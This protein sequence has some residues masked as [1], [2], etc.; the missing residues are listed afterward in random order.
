MTAE[1]TALGF[2]A[3][4]VDWAEN[5]HITMGDS[6]SI[7]LATSAGQATFDRL[8]EHPRLA[9]V[10]FAPPCGTA[11][12]AREKPVAKGR[13]G[14]PPLRSEEFPYG[15]LSLPAEH[16]LAMRHVQ[17]A[18]SQYDFAARSAKAL[19][20]RRV[21]WSMENPASKLFC[22]L[23]P[24]ID[25]LDDEVGD[26]FLH[27]CMHGQRDKLSRLRCFPMACFAPMGLLCDKSHSHKPWGFD[28]DSSRWATALETAYAHRMCQNMARCAE[29]S[30]ESAMGPLTPRSAPHLSNAS[31]QAVSA[32]SP[33]AM[34]HAEA[35]L[36]AS[37]GAQPRG[38][39]HP[40]VVPMCKRVHHAVLAQDSLDA[41]VAADGK[42]QQDVLGVVGR[43]PAGARMVESFNFCGALG[44]STAYRRPARSEVNASHCDML[45]RDS[46]Y[47]GRGDRNHGPSRFANPHRVRESST[48]R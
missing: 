31:V 32:P 30:S 28:R 4:G 44:T 27:H 2:Q 18:N 35:A 22:F 6:V 34:V 42:F 23:P 16:P 41:H 11:S 45:P 39:R 14:P 7:N 3:V 38:Q 43:I 15:L 10:H 47:I 33:S 9:Y 19:T 20:M 13:H 21:P 36:R 37:A 24:V 17:V 1:L 29:A 26:V 25:L 48:L 40:H 46:V 12:R 5:R 8:T